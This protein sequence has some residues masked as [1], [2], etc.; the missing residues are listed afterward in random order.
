MHDIDGG[1]PRP[2]TP[3]QIEPFLVSPDGSFALASGPDRARSMA[4]YPLNGGPPRAVQGLDR[5]D[6]PVQWSSN[7]NEIFVLTHGVPARVFRFNL[8]T[9][10]RTL[11]RELSPSDPAGLIDAAED[12]RITPDGRTYV[13]KYYRNLSDLFLVSGLR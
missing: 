10:R 6:T 8:Q 1:A 3:E 13:Y 9:G 5:S 2:I 4:L 7:P 11:W 12:L